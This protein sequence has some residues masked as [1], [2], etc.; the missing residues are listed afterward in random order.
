M[1]VK[2]YTLEVSETELAR[3]M[4]VMARVT[5]LTDGESIY[6]QAY[7]IFELGGMDDACMEVFN[8]LHEDLGTDGVAAYHLVQE[9]WE[10]ALGIGKFKK[11]PLQQRIENLEKELDELKKL[12]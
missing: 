11:S 5:G 4:F 8:A 3:I 6:N 10:K 1:S 9:E 7:D 2:M 12:L